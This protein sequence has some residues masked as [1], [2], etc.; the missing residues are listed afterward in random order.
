MTNYQEDTALAAGRDV[1]GIK[2][3]QR[4]AVG[5]EQ[6][7]GVRERGRKGGKQCLKQHPSGC[8]L[9]HSECVE[10]RKG[11]CNKGRGCDEREGE[12]F[13]FRKGLA[14]LCK[15]LRCPGCEDREEAGDEDS[16]QVLAA[17]QHPA[18]AELREPLS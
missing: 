14:R 15:L 12:S 6:P 9:A 18:T 3:R 1:G 11:Y 4:V 7:R 2:G 10:A 17:K 8:K 13:S 16:T 5:G